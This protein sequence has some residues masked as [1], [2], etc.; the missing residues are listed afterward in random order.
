[1]LSSNQPSETI[2]NHSEF[3]KFFFHQKVE[4]EMGKRFFFQKN[5]KSCS[6]STK[7]I[8]HYF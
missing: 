2:F 5:K 4:S 6:K 7:N 8:S 3:F 1:M